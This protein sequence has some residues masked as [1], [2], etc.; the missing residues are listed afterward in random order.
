MGTAFDAICSDCGARFQVSDGAG[1]TAMPLHCD[2]CGKEHWVEH[3][4]GVPLTKIGE[5]PACKCGGIF[6]E[7]APARC[8]ECRSTS[9]EG[10][11]DGMTIMYD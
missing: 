9:Y 3:D 5:P 6:K 8:P 1:M 11:P 2:I 10:D 4:A 7:D